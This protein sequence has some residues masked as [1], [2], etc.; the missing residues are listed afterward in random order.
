MYDTLAAIKALA[1]QGDFLISDHGY[2]EMVADDIPAPNVLAGVAAATL[3]EDYPDAAYGPTVLVLQHDAK[4]R[5]IHVVWGIPKDRAGPAV[6]VTAYR[7]HPA[8][9]TSDLMQRKKS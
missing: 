2:D 1:A 4:G 5:P 7:P 8:L 9:W 6:L 3:V